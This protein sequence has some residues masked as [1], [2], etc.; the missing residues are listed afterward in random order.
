MK[1]SSN[2]EEAIFSH[3][4]TLPPDDRAAYL[5][6]ACASDA[7]LQ[8][9]VESLLR[10][11]EE[12]PDFM[13]TSAAGVPR[14]A[15]ASPGEMIGRYK[16][17]QK[18]GEGGIGVVFMAEQEEP[19]RR[20]VAVKVIKLGMDTKEVIARFEAERQALALMDHPNIAR[21]IDAGAT[22]SGRPYFVMELV[23]GIPITKFCDE[24]NLSPKAR[25]ELFT[26]VCHAVQHAHQKGIIHRDLKPSN[27]LV[28]L[29]GR[30][31][32]LRLYSLPRSA[33]SFAGRGGAEKQRSHEDA[34]DPDSNVGV[35][36]PT[37]HERGKR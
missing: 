26:H 33:D 19:I 8:E 17:L 18:I 12:A 5:A 32:D 2:S 9:R 30:A 16:L 27:I 25:L 1:P 3:A 36:I 35:R 21:V 20:R 23:R 29:H 34:K 11:P 37:L 13:A 6:S 7:A 28:T 15:D 10:M 22:T 4:L 31:E 14:L 24:Q